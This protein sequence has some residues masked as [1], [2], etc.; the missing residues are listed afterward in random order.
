MLALEISNVNKHYKNFVA[1]KDINLE[2]QA[3]DFVGLLG[4]NGAGKT[5]LISAISGVNLFT[6][7]IKV[8]GFD[9]KS[10]TVRAKYNLGVVPQELAFDPFLSVYQTLKLQS[11][12]YGI[13]NNELWIDQLLE[14]LY[15]S[16]KKHCGTRSLSGGMKRR[17]MVAQAIV[18]KPQMIILDEPTAG[19]DVEIRRHLWDFII[20][21]NQQGHT[22]LLT[23]HYLEEVEKL[24][25]QIIMLD[26]GKIIAQSSKL[27]LFNTTAQLHTTLSIE[28][29]Q[30]ITDD[31]LLARSNNSSGTNYNFTLNHNQDLASI[32]AQISHLGL[33]IENISL[34]KPS[35]E[36]IFMRHLMHSPRMNPEDSSLKHE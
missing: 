14:R 21:L 19:V 3:G 1:L 24:C 5:S 23:T 2:V 26:R 35:L 8:L 34:N 16:D 29:S 22:I 17:L 32:V 36:E 6:G 15:L 10:D 11:G 7:K 13:K 31:Q 25:N 4:V 20:E 12:L 9:I 18:H 33:H 27:E 30:A 28:T